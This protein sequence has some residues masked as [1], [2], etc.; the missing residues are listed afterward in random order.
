MLCDHSSSV[1]RQHFLLWAAFLGHAPLN[2]Q[3]DMEG[4]PSLVFRIAWSYSSLG[5]LTLNFFTLLNLCWHVILASLALI[6]WSRAFSRK[7]VVMKSVESCSV[8]LNFVLGLRWR[9]GCVCLSLLWRIFVKRS[10]FLETLNIICENPVFTS[11]TQVSGS[12]NTKSIWKYG[13]I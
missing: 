1:P 5:P 12:A 8:Q 10:L 9:R 7:C 6:L 2:S 13:H 4:E 3:N 11:V